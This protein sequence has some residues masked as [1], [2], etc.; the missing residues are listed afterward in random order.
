MFPF[1]CANGR[2][3]VFGLQ[4]GREVDRLRVFL[5]AVASQVS[6]VLI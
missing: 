3:L 4:A 1:A 5:V 6:P 2:G